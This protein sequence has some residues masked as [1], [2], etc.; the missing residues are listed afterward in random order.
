MGS[1]LLSDELV[2]PLGLLFLWLLL[3][4]ISAR[5]SETMILLEFPQ[6]LKRTVHAEMSTFLVLS[7]M[8]LK[9]IPL[10]MEM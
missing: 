6:S 1:G 2:A 9:D 3:G 7:R 5:R 8:W 10:L 4:R